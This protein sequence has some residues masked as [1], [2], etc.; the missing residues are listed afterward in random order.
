MKVLKLKKKKNKLFSLCIAML[1]LNS[2]NVNKYHYRKAQNY[3][4]KCTEMNNGKI[5]VKLNNGSLCVYDSGKL[6]SVGKYDNTVKKGVWYYYK[7][8]NDSII[9]DKIVKY[10]KSDSTILWRRSLI[11]ESW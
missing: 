7:T 3:C 6:S 5:Q 11:N 1:M 9:C 10:S 4:I 8:Y 2:C